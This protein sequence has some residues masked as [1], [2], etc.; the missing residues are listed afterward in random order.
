VSEFVLTEKIGSPCSLV[1]TPALFSHSRS[2]YLVGRSADHQPNA[3]SAQTGVADKLMGRS[4]DHDPTGW[5]APYGCGFGGCVGVRRRDYDRRDVARPA[6]QRVAFSWRPAHFLMI[7]NLF[8]RRP[9]CKCLRDIF[10]FFSH[11]RSPLWP[12]F[13]LILALL[14]RGSSFR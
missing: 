7:Q 8:L 10:V 11:F 2:A 12:L 4:A 6:R 14:L 13:S 5:T 9:Y 3:R 1:P